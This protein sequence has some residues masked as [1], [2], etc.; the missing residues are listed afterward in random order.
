[1]EVD[2]AARDLA[3]AWAGI[4][5]TILRLSW[6]PE[7]AE[8]LNALRSVICGGAD[9]T[10]PD[11]TA[12]VEAGGGGEADAVTVSVFVTTSVVVKDGLAGGVIWRTV[13]GVV[14]GETAGTEELTAS[15]G[16]VLSVE[17]FVFWA[18]TWEMTVSVIQTT[19]VVLCGSDTT[20]YACDRTPNGMPMRRASIIER[21]WASLEPFRKPWFTNARSNPVA[22][23]DICV[24]CADI[25]LVPMTLRRESKVNWQVCQR[26]H[27]VPSWSQE[28]H[29]TYDEGSN[30]YVQLNSG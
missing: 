14:N 16:M 2:A 9:H 19:V 30:L 3:L 29:R 7:N 6:P 18:K 15:L 24:T 22:D 13:D 17:G 26:K 5:L 20:K 10:V 4:P 23:T 11:V 28:F 27:Y 1:V 25:S 21:A 12:D 8:I